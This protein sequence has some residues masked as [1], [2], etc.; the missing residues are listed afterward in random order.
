MNVEVTSGLTYPTAVRQ[1]V[2]L[3][4]AHP[5]PPGS[6]QVTLSP[7]IQ[8]AAFTRRGR[9]RCAGR[10]SFAGHPVVSVVDGCAVVNGATLD[11]PGLVPAPVAD[12]RRSARSPT[13]RRS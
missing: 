7:A 9:R 11:E 4:F 10:R 2:T 3:L 13:A 5:W 12:G 6:Y 1:T 8:A